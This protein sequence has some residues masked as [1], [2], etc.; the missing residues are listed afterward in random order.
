MELIKFIKTLNDKFKL[1]NNQTEKLGSYERK[2]A[3][4]A[5]EMI[6]VSTID[7]EQASIL[8]H[9]LDSFDRHVKQ[10]VQVL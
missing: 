3:I 1:N 2:V 8:R 7:I 10:F 9:Y 6:L 5:H 4:T